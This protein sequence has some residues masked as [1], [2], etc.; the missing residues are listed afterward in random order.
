MQAV[1]SAAHSPHQ[2][3]R[4]ASGVQ[5]IGGA[6]GVLGGIGILIVAAI[7]IPLTAAHGLRPP[8]EGKEA[9]FYDLLQATLPLVLPLFLLQSIGIMVTL[10]FVRA[11]DERL[12]PVSPAAS[13][14][15]A[16]YGYV[17]VATLTLAGIIFV[18]LSETIAAGTSRAAVAPLVAAALALN[19]TAAFGGSLFQVVWLSAINWIAAR[20][21]GLP[22][23]LTYYG[24]LAAAVG[25][26]TTFLGIKGFAPL[27]VSVWY[28]GVGAV[29][30]RRPALSGRA[31]TCE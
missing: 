31:M 2:E 23:G 25:L 18:G 10:V 26:I 11:L 8:L 19:G 6:A 22:R 12:R 14:I 20:H 4:T 15:A 27:T 16:L 17:G 21:R 5:R 13:P 9:Q 3:F 29:M 30:W 7:L 1:H 24:F 28:I